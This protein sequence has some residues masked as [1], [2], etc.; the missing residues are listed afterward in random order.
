MPSPARSQT[1]QSSAPSQRRGLWLRQ[2]LARLAVAAQISG[3]STSCISE[4]RLVRTRHG[5]Y[6]KARRVRIL[7]HPKASN[8]LGGSGALPDAASGV[9]TNTPTTQGPWAQ[10]TSDNGQRA[11]QPP[12]QIGTNVVSEL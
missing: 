11:T 6:A 4:G 7:R 10:H 2:D 1:T 8:R 3:H 5:V 9:T 12:A